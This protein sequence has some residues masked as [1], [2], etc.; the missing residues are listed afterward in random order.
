ML[1]YTVQ[2]SVY[3]IANGTS[4]DGDSFGIFDTMPHC[5]AFNDAGFCVVGA[6]WRDPSPTQPKVS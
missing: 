4:N 2:N 1:E 3:Y 5:L 6:G